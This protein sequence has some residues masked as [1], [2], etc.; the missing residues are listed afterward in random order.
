LKKCFENIWSRNVF[1]TNFNTL[2]G[3]KVKT[4]IKTVIRINYNLI[5]IPFKKYSKFNL[6][7]IAKFKLG[8]TN[9][10]R[11]TSGYLFC[12]KFYQMTTIKLYFNL[13]LNFDDLKFEPWFILRTVFIDS[14]IYEK[15][16]LIPSDSNFFCL[17]EQTIFPFSKG[18]SSQKR[19]VSI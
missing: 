9:E 5:I 3:P 17:S 6:L 11:F 2:I 7:L 4:L 16:W 19:L 13:K 15:F 8:F 18:T 1:C 14:I 12:V 10:S